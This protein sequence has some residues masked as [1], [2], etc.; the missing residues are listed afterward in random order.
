[1]NL[2]EYSTSVP[3]F[4]VDESSNDLVFVVDTESFFVPSGE[5]VISPSLGNFFGRFLF[6]M[7]LN[8]YVIDS[9]TYNQFDNSNLGEDNFHRY[10]RHCSIRRMPDLAHIYSTIFFGTSMESTWR[11]SFFTVPNIR[12]GDGRL[13]LPY[14]YR[15]RLKD[16]SVVMVNVYLKL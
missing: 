8:I 11:E 9:M 15:S 1:L 2:L 5:C 12:D 16:G 7:K 13:V 6:L 10:E 14:E 4:R 3:F